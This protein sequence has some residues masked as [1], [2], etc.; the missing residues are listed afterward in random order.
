MRTA[1]SHSGVHASYRPFGTTTS[2]S[3]P[4]PGTWLSHSAEPGWRVMGT[5]KSVQ[6]SAPVVG[7]DHRGVRN[8]EQKRW[9]P[10][11]KYGCM[12]GSCTLCTQ[13]QLRREPG[14]GRVF[15]ELQHEIEVGEGKLRCVRLPLTRG[16]RCATR[17]PR[18]NFNFMLNLALEGIRRRTP[19][20]F[21]VKLKS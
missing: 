13:L 21:K 15:R 6:G 1:S 16:S 3:P 17:L 14:L 18:Q 4:T 2:S 19:P 5:Q 12:I 10:H 11:L 9:A 7:T 8:P 20:N